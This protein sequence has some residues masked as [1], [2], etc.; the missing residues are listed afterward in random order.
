MKYIFVLIL[1]STVTFLEKGVATEFADFNKKNVE[2][3][4]S[5]YLNRTFSLN[6]TI[7]QVKNALLKHAENPE[8]YIEILG[9]IITLSK[10][11]RFN[12]GYT[13]TY[14][15]LTSDSRE[16]LTTLL[17]SASLY[18]KLPPNA[19]TFKAL[20]E[21]L[22]IFFENS[23]TNYNESNLTDAVKTI[24]NRLISINGSK[25]HDLETIETILKPQNGLVYFRELE[26]FSEDAKKDFLKKLLTNDNIDTNTLLKVATWYNIDDFIEEN[27]SKNPQETLNHCISIINNGVEAMSKSIAEYSMTGNGSSA[28]RVR[29]RADSYNKTC[30][31]ILQDNMDEKLAEN[32]RQIIRTQVVRVAQTYSDM[33]AMMA[34]NMSSYFH[35]IFT[36]ELIS[37]YL[38]YKLSKHILK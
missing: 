33:D 5:S 30:R 34:Q 18:E 13:Y 1:L 27:Y 9:L 26:L 16:V 36:E 19:N 14:L 23:R 35:Y 38:G 21:A 29:E 24:A 37:Q 28:M 6:P 12:L 2:L 7:S 22:S 10:E 25:I 3:I 4:A 15:D 8:E 31:N 20:K 11:S 32:L 17:N